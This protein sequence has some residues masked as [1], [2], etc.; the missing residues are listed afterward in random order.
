MGIDKAPIWSHGPLE[1]EQ[2][3]KVSSL[4]R[5]EFFCFLNE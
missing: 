1:D 3:L 2:H 5:E 4:A